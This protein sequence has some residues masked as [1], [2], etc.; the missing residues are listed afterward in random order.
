MKLNND[1]VKNVLANIVI[2]SLLGATL[3]NIAEIWTEIEFFYK[4]KWS[5]MSLFAYAM[6]MGLMMQGLGKSESK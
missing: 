1:K 6:I 2:F 3:C 5:L 4:L